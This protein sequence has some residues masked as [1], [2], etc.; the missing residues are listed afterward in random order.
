[1]PTLGLELEMVTAALRDGA[2]HPVGDAYFAALAAC[3]RARGEAVTLERLAGRT[4]GVATRAVKSGIDNGFNLLESSLAPVAGAR[5]LA[6]LARAVE[7]ELADVAAALA[8][9]GAVFVNLAQ[10]PFA[11][12]DRDS[13]LRL[14]APRPI[15]DYA[16]DERGWD[17]SVGI[18]AKAQNG[19]TT[20]LDPGEAA[21]VLNMLLRAAP[22]FIALFANSPFE[23]GRPSGCKETRLTLWPRM[24][25]ASRFPAD[26][27]RVGLPPRPFASL[28]DYVL[29]TFGP[30]TAMHCVPVDGGGYKGGGALA[31]VEGDPDLLSFLAQGPRRGRVL[32][33]GALVTVT[34]GLEH[35]EFLQWNNF[36]DMRLRFLLRDITPVDAFL[37]ALERPVGLEA[38][39]ARHAKAF[40]VEN[41]VAGACFPDAEMTALDETA[42]ASMPLA[43]SALQAGL[44][45][46]WRPAAAKLGRWSWEDTARLR[47]AAIRQALDDTGVRALCA[48]VLDLAADGLSP[49]ERPALAYPRHVLRSGRTG[50]DRALGRFEALSGGAA[51]RLRTIV[52][53][54]RFEAV[55]GPELG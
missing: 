38:F 52:I 51:E 41:R 29:W 49:A 30:G 37:A 4:V 18:D 25:A 2:S 54:R 28:R 27:D 24:V 9:E 55:A 31:R 12:R 8:G 16:N 19:P 1:M 47:R 45:R 10:H 48:T 6:A 34:P 50:A 21:S 39:F 46:N 20:E 5:P 15:Y 35:L 42:A 44:V 22:A 17:H 3:K 32:A 7:R 33:D 13:Y 36:L 26:A 53:E 23:D 14:R 43:A 11:P 40:Y